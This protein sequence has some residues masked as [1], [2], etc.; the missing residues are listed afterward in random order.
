MQVI[1]LLSIVCW[2]PGFGKHEN[3]DCPTPSMLCFAIS[4]SAQTPSFPSHSVTDTSLCDIFLVIFLSRLFV[5]GSIN[6]MDQDFF[7]FFLV[8][9]GLVLRTE[10]STSLWIKAQSQN[11][12]WLRHPAFHTAKF[13]SERVW[14]ISSLANYLDICSLL[15]GCL[16]GSLVLTQY[17][18]NASP[19]GWTLPLM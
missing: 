4:L 13:V 19:A 11:V 5:P 8:T 6:T 18:S 10:N 15:C 12:R 14:W 3:T 16:G 9:Q 1:F 2:P 7:F 17:K